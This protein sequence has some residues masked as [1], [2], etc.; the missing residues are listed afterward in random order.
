[1]KIP[2]IADF[3]SGIIFST[4]FL[5]QIVY[6]IFNFKKRFKDSE[7]S[8]TQFG[9]G[10]I[11]A[12]EPLLAIYAFW[13]SSDSDHHFAADDIAIVLFALLATFLTIYT[14]LFIQKY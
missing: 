13:K 10:Q 8:T 3:V 2:A 7:F 1:M 6:F 12:Y 5:L 11:M 4:L 9:C 14:F